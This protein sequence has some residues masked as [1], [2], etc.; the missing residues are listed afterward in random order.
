MP[1]PYAL[2]VSLAVNEV[3][4]KECSIKGRKM[5]SKRQFSP[6]RLFKEYSIGEFMRFQVILSLEVVLGV[7][8]PV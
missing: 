6:P 8:L 1:W 7:K 2:T 3:R 5:S 4:K